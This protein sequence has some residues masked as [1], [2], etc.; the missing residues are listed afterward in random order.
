M[1]GRS[2][3]RPVWLSAVALLVLA[4]PAGAT[5]VVDVRVG[6][7]PTFTRVVFEL[8]AP[9]GYR[10]ERHTAPDGTNEILVTLEAG[11]NPRSV[12]RSSVM[13]E[14]VA[15]QDG[16]AKSVAHIRLRKEPSRVKE[17]ILAKPPR[18]VFDLLLPEKEL[19][20][21]AAKE[22]AA[23]E[24]AEQAARERAA[25]EQPPKE[26]AAREQ[27]PKEQAAKEQAAKEQ[28]AKEQAAKEQAAKE[29]AAKEQ[30]AR[31][32]A[33]KEQ[34]AK[35]Q[36]AKEQAAREQAAKEQASVEGE[37]ATPGRVPK[38]A[39]R[40]REPLQRPGAGK[41]A[42]A[43]EQVAQSGAEAQP[44]DQRLRELR[45]GKQPQALAGAEPAAEPTPAAPIP[46][47]KPP[48]L[49]GRPEKLA[50]PPPAPGAAAPAAASGRTDW[51]LW[52]GAA[53]GVI[54]VLL[55][56][57]L[58]LRRRALPNDLDV[59]ALAEESLD[60]D[61]GRPRDGFSLSDALEQPEPTV[62]KPAPRA[63]PPQPAAPRPR[64]E[65]PK[66]R[67]DIKAGPGR[68][69]EEEAEKENETMDTHSRD[70]PLKQTASEAPT[71]AG[72]G[73]DVAR[74]VRE[75]ERRVAQLETRLD[76]QIDARERL[77]RQVTAQA[78][79]LRV[80]RAAIARTQRALR[81]LNR[82]EE[83]QATE[84]ALRDPGKNA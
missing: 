37:V 12:T 82:G 81:S 59:T 84:P 8:D 30:A 16:A 20:A 63:A 54:A 46:S 56:V 29:Q 13:V 48:G 68:F 75:L 7:H 25:R 77:E 66:T 22:R 15:V 41:D 79:E 36:A 51:T 14:R 45:A 28:A 57:A 23:K 40:G 39:E 17:M 71:Q 9:A 58:L 21:L 70:L 26:Q 42:S 49:E 73:G 33:A 10:I 55:V 11:S 74:L 24:R 50:A 35:E 4:A 32:Q 67:P 34:A 69:D 60:E 44:L 76:E 52:L 18:I 27:P 6:N 80:Q 78:E 65:T 62:A 83:D 38:N 19:A 43:P 31:E 53:G 5:R 3:A 72:L 61:R 47:G 64:V 2:I 1:S